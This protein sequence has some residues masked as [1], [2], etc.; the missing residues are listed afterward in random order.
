MAREMGRLRALAVKRES[1]PGMHHD[2][3]GLY[4]QV[5]AAGAKSWIHRYMLNGRVREMGLGQLHI[6]SL[7]DAR[8]RAAEYRRQR[9][10][11]IDPIDARKA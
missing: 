10:D 6:I 3:G 4:L 11:G 2:G 8:T 9:L 1:Q 5:T 7:S